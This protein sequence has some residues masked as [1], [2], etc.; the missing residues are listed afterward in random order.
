MEDICNLVFSFCSAISL[1][2]WAQV[3]KQWRNQVYTRVQELIHCNANVYQRRTLQ[4]LQQ[5]HARHL[6]AISKKKCMLC[7][8]KWKGAIAPVWGVPAHPACVRQRLINTYYLK[9]THPVEH[10]VATLPVET[11]IGYSQFYRSSYAYKVVWREHCPAVPLEA[12]LA[13]YNEHH[14]AEITEFRDRIENERQQALARSKAKR[15][16]AAAAKRIKRASQIH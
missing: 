11:R 14:A 7:G 10:V 8:K 9:K 15:K 13:W 6:Y 16:A 5:P 4:H 2:Q 1:S 12:T 3:S